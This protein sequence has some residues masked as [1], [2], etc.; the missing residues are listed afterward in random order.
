MSTKVAD[1]TG[2]APNFQMSAF[3]YIMAGILVVLML[4]LLP[5]LVPAYVLWRVFFGETK[6][7]HSFESWRESEQPPGDS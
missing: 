3:G 1:S 4:P 5:V 6:F 7:E 2:Y